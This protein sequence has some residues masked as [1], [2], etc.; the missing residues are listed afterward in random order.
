MSIR[1][2]K[3]IIAVNN[4]RDKRIRYVVVTSGEKS[5]NGM[6]IYPTKSKAKEFAKYLREKK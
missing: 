1:I 2:L 5:G 3:K 4:P 6:Y